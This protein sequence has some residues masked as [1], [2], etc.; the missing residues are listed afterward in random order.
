MP[1]V[2]FRRVDIDL[3]TVRFNVLHLCI[4]DVQYSS[5]VR[6]KGVLYALPVTFYVLSKL[7]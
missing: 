1:A 6:S 2:T 4:S 7:K 5:V 3:A